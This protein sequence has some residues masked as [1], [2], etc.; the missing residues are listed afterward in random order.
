M[1]DSDPFEKARQD[2]GV[3]TCPFQGES[4]PMI[5]RH[6]DVHTLLTVSRFL[7]HDYLERLEA[8]APEGVEIALDL[9]GGE[10]LVL[11]LDLA[12]IPA[13]GQVQQV[14]R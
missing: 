4:L 1:S 5:L 3:L 8:A 7:S 9:V 10:S 11:G 13:P 2:E 12:L 14:A 6:A